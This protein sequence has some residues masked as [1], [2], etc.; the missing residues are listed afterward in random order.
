MLWLE[1]VTV[2]GMAHG[3]VGLPILA[4]HW[5]HG[6]PLTLHTVMC[7]FTPTRDHGKKGIIKL[8]CGLLF[9]IVLTLIGCVNSDMAYS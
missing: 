8:S 4:T 1:S 7:I 3:R 5:T 9:L 2:G 6:I